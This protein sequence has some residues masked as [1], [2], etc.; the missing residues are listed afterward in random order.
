MSFFLASFS[1]FA[2]ASL[3]FLSS[4]V[5]LCHSVCCF[6]TSGHSRSHVAAA[7]ITVKGI[8]IVYQSFD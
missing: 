1:F 2:A 3:R 4:C 7:C 5:A 8:I 6:A